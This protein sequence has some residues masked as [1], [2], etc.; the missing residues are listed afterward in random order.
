MR[1][2]VVDQLADE[3]MRQLLEQHRDRIVGLL[4]ETPGLSL[5]ENTCAGFLHGFMTVAAYFVPDDSVYQQSMFPVLGGT[6]LAA[7]DAPPEATPNLAG[8][9]RF[10]ADLAAAMDA[11]PDAVILSTAQR[12]IL[13]E[14]IRGGFATTPDVPIDHATLA[15]FIVGLMYA[16]NF[17]PSDDATGPIMLIATVRQI[18]DDLPT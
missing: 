18:A 7:I 2:G 10:L 15:G 3:E 5:D 6:Y 9:R 12:A 1:A 8:A 11:D 13:E 4:T 14:R 17:L 16:T